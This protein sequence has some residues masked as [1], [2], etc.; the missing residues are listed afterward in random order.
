MTVYPISWHKTQYNRIS[1]IHF[2]S[3]S[4]HPIFIKIHTALELSTKHWFRI[5]IFSRFS[6]NFGSSKVWIFQHLDT[7]H[8]I[9]SRKKS[10]ILWIFERFWK[11]IFR[12]TKYWK[13]F[14][15]IDDRQIILFLSKEFFGNRILS[16]FTYLSLNLYVNAK[17]VAL[18]GKFLRKCQW[19]ERLKS[20][21]DSKIQSAYTVTNIDC[22]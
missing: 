19:V 3:L 9:Q 18:T 11:N 5:E 12:G 1:R 20:A 8:I 22:H 21:A 13:F 17:H 16:H 2:L 6:E 14:M 10:W 4:K 15:Q 7:D